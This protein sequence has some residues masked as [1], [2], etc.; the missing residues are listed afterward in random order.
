MI[1]ELETINNNIVT[2]FTI[3]FILIFLGI[4]I[5]SF[6]AYNINERLDK[7]DNHVNIEEVTR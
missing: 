1:D 2:S 7:I 5:N 4:L 3:L 6:D